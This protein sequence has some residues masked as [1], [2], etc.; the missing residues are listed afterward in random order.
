MTQRTVASAGAAALVLAVLTGGCASTGTTDTGPATTTTSPS[1]P[2]GH[3]HSEQK[4][5][6][7][8]QV[9]LLMER[10]LGHHTILMIRLMRGPVDGE[11]RFVDAASD[12]LE[13]NTDELAEA[14]SM[15][16]DDDAAAGFVNL[17]S[18]HVESLVAYS[19][20]LANGDQSAQDRAQQAL[21][22]YCDEYGRFIEDL[23]EGGASAEAVTE[24]VAM[25]VH[26]LVAATDAYEAG[27]YRSA[28][29]GERTAYSAMFGQGKALSRAALVQ[30]TG[31]LA[32]GFASR[33]T[34]L[35]SALG[36]L[37]G[38]HVELA[39]DATRA[40]VVGS[41]SA[42]AAAAALNENTQEI[43][44]A[45]Q[46]ALG[47]EL[48]ATFSD[49]WAAHIDAVVQF[50]VAVADDDDEAQARARAE[51][52][53][54]PIQLGRVLPE[55]AEGRVAAEAVIAALQEHDEQLLQQI[56]AY[57]ARDYVTSHDLAYEGYDHMY[58]IADTLARALEGHAAGAAPKGGAATG[59]GGTA[60]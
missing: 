28:Y 35:R 23:T 50:A 12:A 17:W 43:I 24:G 5:A 47:D 49:I 11:D 53:R 2:A 10:L 13:R 36:R 20:A 59:A 39:F 19:R 46:G 22:R 52:D 3:D 44:T 34:G 38:E 45:M 15:V 7:P 29:D 1:A 21:D 9:R 40:I 60:G 56:T 8:R 33:A 41:P 42:D 58:A 57:A 6:T 31:E 14:I 18:D 48:A 26:H 30:S 51:L 37:L 54:F 32:A 55:V 16:Y 27:D 25:H 4:A